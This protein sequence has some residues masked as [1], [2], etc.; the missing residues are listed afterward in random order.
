[1]TNSMSRL[2]ITCKNHM[3][4]YKTR[5]PI[6]VGRNRLDFTDLLKM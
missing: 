5:G 6:M 4:I 3:D 1:M 2:S